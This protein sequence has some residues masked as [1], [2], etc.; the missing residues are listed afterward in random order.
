MGRRRKKKPKKDSDSMR[1]L[2]SSLAGNWKD[3]LD[4][5]GM[6]KHEVEGEIDLFLGRYVSGDV[7]KIVTGYGTGVVRQETQ[8]VLQRHGRVS[9]FEERVGGGAFYVVIK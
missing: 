9:R 8:R 1:M 5:H 6:R 7:L 3:E 2:A 4:L